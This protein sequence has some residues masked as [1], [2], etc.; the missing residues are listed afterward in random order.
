MASCETRN[1]SKPNW[2]HPIGAVLRSSDTFLRDSV[3]WREICLAW[4]RWDPCG[5]TRVEDRTMIFRPL[6]ISWKLAQLAQVSFCL[7]E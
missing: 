7:T 5:V 4:L 3:W 1:H 2:P 6:G